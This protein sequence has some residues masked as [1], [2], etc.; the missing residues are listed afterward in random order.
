MQLSVELQILECLEDQLDTFPF[1]GDDKS[2]ILAIYGN[3]IG[4][5]V[6]LGSTNFYPNLLQSCYEENYNQ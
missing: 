3:L 2:H 1:F 4:Y 6:H 5:E